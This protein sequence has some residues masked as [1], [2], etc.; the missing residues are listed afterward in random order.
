LDRVGDAPPIENTLISVIGQVSI[1]FV[2]KANYASLPIR[3]DG[4]E[5]KVTQETR[6]LRF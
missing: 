6:R 5:V 4:E 3:G 2:V 1:N